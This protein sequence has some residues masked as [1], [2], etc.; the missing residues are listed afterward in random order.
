[1]ATLTRAT[2][3]KLTQR[4]TKDIEIGG[5][6]VRIQKPT[7][8]EYSQYQMSMV[9][10]DGKASIS[11][12]SDAIRLLVAKMWIDDGGNRIFADNELLELGS[13]DLDFYQ[14]L[15]EECQQFAQGEA[16]KTLGESDS[17][18]DSSSPVESA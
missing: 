11:T 3:G 1:M 17:T 6:V 9:D 2:L 18:G 15:S 16:L 4:A 12:F 8:L 13:I 5:N 10:K 7:P 14:K